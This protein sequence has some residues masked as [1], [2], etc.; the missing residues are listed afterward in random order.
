MKREREG[1]WKESVSVNTA[2]W[3]QFSQMHA[4][5]LL[6]GGCIG[7]GAVSGIIRW[8]VRQW[9]PSKYYWNAATCFEEFSELGMIRKQSR[10]KWI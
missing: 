3:V 7:G 1:E 5:M 6:D 2:G 10:R 9:S 8:L 4:L